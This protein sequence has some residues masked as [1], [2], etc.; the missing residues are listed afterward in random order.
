M[1]VM[2]VRVQRG[3]GGADTSRVIYYSLGALNSALSYTWAAKPNSN[4]NVAKVW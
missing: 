4:L 2:I 3:K 1:M